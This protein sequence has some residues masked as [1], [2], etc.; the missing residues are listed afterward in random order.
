MKL[1]LV[2]VAD[3]VGCHFLNAY[4]NVLLIKHLNAPLWLEA[5][6]CA[7]IEWYLFVFLKI[8]VMQFYVNYQIKS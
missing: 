8:L 3:K 6:L 1:L 5:F 2:S 4:A 7:S